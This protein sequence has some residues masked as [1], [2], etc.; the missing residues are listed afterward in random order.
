MTHNM[1]VCYRK[2][3][4]EGKS[5]AVDFKGG[6]NLAN[7]NVKFRIG[8]KHRRTIERAFGSRERITGSSEPPRD[9]VPGKRNSSQ[10][11]KGV[12]GCSFSSTCFV[13][14]D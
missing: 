10:S 4:V 12:I 9:L 14:R 8:M 7:N 1:A 13:C 3:L 5:N 11:A 6:Q 2:Q